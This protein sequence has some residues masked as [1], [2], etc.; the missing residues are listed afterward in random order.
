MKLLKI[1]FLLAFFGMLFINKS[2]G[3]GYFTINGAV[4][5]STTNQI[6]ANASV[7]VNYG[8][9][10]LLADEL[11]KFKFT[12]KQGE[13][14]LVVKYVNYLPFRLRILVKEDLNLDIYLKEFSSNL[15]QVTVSSKSADNNIKRPL[16]GVSTLNIIALKKIPT[17]LGEVDIFRGLAMLPGVTS[18][19]EASNGVNI[20]GG[21]TDQNLIL[22]DE[23]PLFNPTHMFGLFSA[24]P[25]DA[26]SSFD[27]YKGNVPSR[28]GGRAAAV[29]DVSLAN[30]S[31]TK[32]KVVGA[33]GLVSNKILV[34]VPL[35]KDKL[36]LLVAGRLSV[37]DWLLPLASSRLE[38]IKAKFGDGT[39]K[40]FYKINNKNTLSLTTYNSIDFVQTNLLGGI[41]NINST[42]TQYDYRTLNLSGKW[43]KVVN[44][45]L[46]IQTILVQ[47]KY[48]PKTL[49][50]ELNTGNKVI[51]YQDINW[52]Q[53]RTNI[54]YTRGKHNIETGA[55]ATYYLINPGELKPGKSLAVSSIVT[56]KENG[57]ELGGFLSDEFD[58]TN[59]ISVSAG[60]R[61]SNYSTFGA[62]TYRIYKPGAERIK[63]NI[64]D[65][66]SYNG[67]QLAKR[68]GG[69][70]PRIGVNIALNNESSIKLGYNSMR[71]YLQVIS[72]TTTPIPTSRWKSSDPN[73]KP[74]ISNLV[75]GGYFRNFDENVYEFSSEV[76]YKTTD[77]IID[78]KPGASFLLQKN[79]ETE[80][81]QGK[82]KAYGI[83]LMF[84][85]KKG[86]FTGWINYT[87]ARSLNKVKEGNAYGQQIN[88]GNWYATNYDRPNTINA[89]IVIAQTKMHDFSFNFTYSS[90]RPYTVPKAFI[91]SNG[92]TFPFYT[93]R[94]N[95][96]I[97]D[98]HR[99]DFSWNIYNPK[100][101]HKKYKGNW[102]FTVYNLYGRK[103]A[104]S[105]F[106]KSTE[107]VST[108]FKLTIFGAP[109]LSL[110]Y[111]FK[112]E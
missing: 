61:Y 112:F 97:P 49:L 110:S 64:T 92:V 111:N 85:K 108:P 104:Y 90:G 89:A 14:I 105:V 7:N 47:S 5:D 9:K 26:V 54:N 30:P 46:N 84:S 86:E 55:D 103:N 72:N 80:L 60:L 59:K 29:L 37:N 71:Q 8:Q 73:I 100:N 13:L 10:I 24:F 81:L 91:Q 56:P 17:V 23:A 67:G 3:Q 39:A 27:L 93:D 34:D 18:V 87:Y 20:R 12:I 75:S 107:R 52:K 69:F 98:Y 44:D 74:Q 95:A 65:S 1:Y 79:I 4:K 96:R 102:N 88:Y 43:L 31:L 41:N 63:S 53:L 77:N 36:G 94:N 68:Y 19:G 22:L 11:G 51:V 25:S 42:T 83:E 106:I 21:T 82:N 40:L 38:G 76:Y 57:L 58:I 62:S 6:L 45:K 48:V 2:F 70:E 101:L 99:L 109:I 33:I 15:E 78:Y 16:M 50:P 66:V 35:I 28:Y 32:A